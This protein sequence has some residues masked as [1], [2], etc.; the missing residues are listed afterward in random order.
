MKVVHTPYYLNRLPKPSDP[1][2]L[3]SSLVSVI[4][5]LCMI[6]S[7]KMVKIPYCYFNC[8]TMTNIG[9]FNLAELVLFINLVSL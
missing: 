7:Q 5:S 9:M 6:L 1:Q 3:L 8:Y 2:V 4:F